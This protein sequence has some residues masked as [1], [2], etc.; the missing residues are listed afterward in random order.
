M[1][2]LAMKFEQKRLDRSAQTGRNQTQTPIYLAL[3]TRSRAQ[4]ARQITVSRHSGPKGLEWGT[5]LRQHAGEG[6][7]LGECRLN[8]RRFP[9]ALIL[10]PGQLPFGRN[11]PIPK[12]CCDL[13]CG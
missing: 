9:A 5:K 12:A 8:L 3:E 4:V 10:H 2:A 1:T 6:I 13:E 7:L 11:S